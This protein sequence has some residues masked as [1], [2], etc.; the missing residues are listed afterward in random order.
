[1]G[2][3]D[4]GAAAKTRG[5]QEDL[6]TEKRKRLLQALEK[7]NEDL[8]ALKRIIKAVQATDVRLQPPP[9]D[10]SGDGNA[11]LLAAKTC[12]EK[13]TDALAEE[14]N[15]PVEEFTSSPLR[16]YSANSTVHNTGISLFF[17]SYPTAEIIFEN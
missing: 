9:R 16:S 6:L 3:E 11:G 4:I 13:C 15:V 14:P 7:C 2:L 5:F 8:E 17:I 1:M 12:M 10:H